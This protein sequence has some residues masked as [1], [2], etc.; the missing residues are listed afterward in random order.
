MNK[1]YFD[2]SIRRGVVAVFGAS[3]E[4]NYYRDLNELLDSLSEPHEII[5]EA[6]FSSF[7]LA[8]RYALIERCEREGH[9]LLTTP[10]RLTGRKRRAMGYTDADK[11]DEIDVL[12]IR[13]LVLDGTHLKRPSLPSPSSASART[14]S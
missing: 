9:T 2:W 6:T 10:N 11:S 7:D 4:P 8:A 1:I 12:V 5:G 14:P 13:Q 3:D